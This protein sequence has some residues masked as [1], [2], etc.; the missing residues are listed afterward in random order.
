[1]ALSAAQRKANDK[2]IKENYR[3]VKLSMPKEEAEILERY[4]NEHKLKKAGFIRAA[5]K[6]KMQ[7][8]QSLPTSRQAQHE[9]AEEKSTEPK[10][11][12]ERVKADV[13]QIV[14]E[15]DKD[16]EEE[17]FAEWKKHNRW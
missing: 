13:E 8:D 5:I 16:T 6:E 10:S 9:S 7:R 12:I 11:F 14:A 1:M 2:Y 15:T 4:C 3:Q 17:N